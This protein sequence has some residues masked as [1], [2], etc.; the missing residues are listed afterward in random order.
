MSGLGT[1]LRQRFRRDRIQ[2]LVWVLGFAA[3]ASVGHS[4]VSQSYGTPKDRAGVIVLL[5]QTPSVLV[6]RG[7]PQGT[8]SDAFQFM[9]L[10]AF[11]GVLI[12]L[13]ATFLAVRHTRGDEE[14]GRA[15]L[16]ESTPA[17]RITPLVATAL[18]GVI[19]VAVIALVNTGGFLL[20]G[21]DAGG[22]VLAGL[23]LASVGGCFLG[24]GLLAAQVMRTSRGANG[25]AAALVAA[26]YMVR[27]IGDATGTVDVDDPLSMTAGWVS[28]LS[29]IG[30]G[31]RTSPFSDPTVWPALLG[32]ALGAIAFAGAL[33]LRTSR[34]IDSSIIGERAGRAHARPSLAGPIALV[35]RQLRNPTIGWLVAAVL[36]GLLVG[37]LSETLTGNAPA[38]VKQNLGD[39]VGSIAGPNAHGD[40]VDLFIVA[41]FSMIGA[42]AAVCAVQSVARA[43]QDEANGTAEIVLSTAVSR[44]RWF[45]AYLV[46]A[47]ASTVLVVGVAVLGAI[48]G[49]SGAGAPS[50]TVTTITS[51]ALAQLPAVFLLLALVALVFAIVPRLTIG[52]GW[53]LLLLAI[54]IGQ[55]GGLFG[56]PEW[57][58]DL[59]P[60]SHTP[61]VTEANADW[62]SAW[63]MLGLA[64]VVA[65]ASVLLVRR[66]DVALGG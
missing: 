6:L 7:T 22:A 9:L 31:Q 50:G 56:L 42:I 12:G 29:P 40:L 32:L 34:D 62:G 61:I 54:F 8:Q 35:W 25:L 44:I 30:W 10:F 14:Q 37:S 38:D 59:S 16:I 66:R 11:L 13:M 24:I 23:A 55:F 47:V 58:R 1:L 17:G 39:T 43:R 63:L 53:T 28:W 60:F 41:M 52:L 5:E 33:A 21:A 2:L 27:G 51:A 4:A 3:L 45:V 48:A 15:E 49:A 20:Y 57:A 26:A 46:I 36:F 19:A 65:A 64:V 18:E